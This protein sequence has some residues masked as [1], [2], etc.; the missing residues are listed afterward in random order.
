MFMFKSRNPGGVFS[1]YQKI[2]IM[3]EK[4]NVGEGCWGDCARKSNSIN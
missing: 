2:M 4:M 1:G 3:E